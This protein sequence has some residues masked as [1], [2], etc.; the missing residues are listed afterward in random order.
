[1][2]I[3]K[4]SACSERE[5]FKQNLC[6]TV[7]KINFFYEQIFWSKILTDFYIWKP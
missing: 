7:L 6:C 5:N 1:M 3:N 4:G 2:F